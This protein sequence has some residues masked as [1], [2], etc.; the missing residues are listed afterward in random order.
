MPWFAS[1]A[2]VMA[3]AAPTVLG[4]DISLPHR[5]DMHSH[6]VPDFYR[7]TL[8][9]NG[10]E[11]VGGIEMFPTWN[12]SGHLAMMKSVNASKSILSISA[13]GTHLV[14]GNDALARNVTRQTNM[15]AAALKK[16]Y[17]DQLGYWAS[18]PLPDVNAS[19]GEIDIA[20][21]EGA[22]GFVMMT[23]YW[24][25]YLGDAA[26]DPVFAKL[27]DVGA[28]VFIHPTEPC[29]KHSNQTS[30][31]DVSDAQPISDDI[32]PSSMFE[33]LFDTA[34]ATVNLF[35]SGTVNRT[36]NVTYILSHV[37]GAL[38]PIL[39]RFVNFPRPNAP[40][41]L[42]ATTVRRQLETQFFFD[43][44][45]FTFDR[46]WGDAGQ[47]KAFVKGFDVSYDRFLYGGDYPFTP[48]ATIEFFAKRMYGGMAT[49]FN[50]SEQGG[51]YLGNAEKILANAHANTARY[52]NSPHD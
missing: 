42:N 10:L 36:P 50:A 11:H 49:L 46:T 6:F 41:H 23:N 45:G 5:I 22:D 33:F 27:N 34:R 26:L 4:Q 17:P 29:I 9:E 47:L 25:N 28:A 37:G 43:L 32:Y 1:F 14:A 39:T 35:A 30:T 40:V 16:Q 44:A 24:G 3:A 51:V 52:M 20:L 13:P 19:L 8:V 48:E 12:V 15:Y 38:P 18:L 2:F 21:A 7:Q 31:S